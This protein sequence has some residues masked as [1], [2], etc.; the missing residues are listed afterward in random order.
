MISIFYQQP[1]ANGLKKNLVS[2]VHATAG[3]RGSVHL[4]KDGFEILNEVFDSSD[5]VK[6]WTRYQKQFVY[7]DEI[8]WDEIKQATLK[9]WSLLEN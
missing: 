4:L 5:S 6:K 1:K 9:L 8:M 3:K 2:A 7:A